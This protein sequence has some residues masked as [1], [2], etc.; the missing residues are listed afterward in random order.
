ML[1]QDGRLLINLDDLDPISKQV[2]PLGAQEEMES[3]KIWEPVTN[4]ILAKEYSKATKHKQD[5]EQIQREKAAE[6]KEKGVE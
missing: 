5:I 4:A 2:R 3:R 1:L 6:R